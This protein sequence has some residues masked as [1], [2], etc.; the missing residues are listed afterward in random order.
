MNVKF[1]WVR[2]EKSRGVL[3]QCFSMSREGKA[4]AAPKVGFDWSVKGM[5]WRQLCSARPGAPGP[6]KQIRSIRK[7]RVFKETPPSRRSP[8]C[9][10]YSPH[11]KVST[12]IC[13]SNAS[14]MVS[15]R[16]WKWVWMD[17]YMVSTSGF[18]KYG[19]DLEAIASCRR[20]AHLS[21][22]WGMPREYMLR[23][24]YREEWVTCWL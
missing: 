20:A 17:V 7:R 2:N 19:I 21:V 12:L 5:V 11:Q 4:L 23:D 10:L 1:L 22:N 3:V 14:H 15:I 9:S 6:S 13:V 24:V 8:P 18:V 16:S